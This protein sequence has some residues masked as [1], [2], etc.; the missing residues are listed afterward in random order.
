MAS[1]AYDL[2]GG[3]VRST[4]NPGR[5]KGARVK[6]L[7]KKKLTTFFPAPKRG[8]QRMYARFVKVPKKTYTK[9]SKKTA[10]VRH[11]ASD[12]VARP[13]RCAWSCTLKT[14][15]S[16]TPLQLIQMLTRAGFL[17]DWTK[18]T[19]PHCGKGRVNSLRCRKQGGQDV[20]VYRC[21]D[22]D[23][24]QFISPQHS[25]PIFSNANGQDFVPLKNQAEIL[26]CLVLN[27]KNYQPVMSQT[28]R[29]RCVG[30]SLR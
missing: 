3:G 27:I 18:T 20:W 17:K 22:R 2:A 19:C 29:A 7:H 26:F 16:K 12:L 21:G 10:Y 28:R 6:K 25:H 15:Q 1:D 5:R 14:I 11:K 24:L 23:C 13:E 30:V 4:R 9:L 8:K